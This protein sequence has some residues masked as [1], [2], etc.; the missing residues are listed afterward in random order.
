MFYHCITYLESWWPMKIISSNTTH[1]VSPRVFQHRNSDE[2]GQRPCDVY[3]NFWTQQEHSYWWLVFESTTSTVDDGSLIKTGWY[4]LLNVKWINHNYKWWWYHD[5]RRLPLSRHVLQ[6][7]QTWAIFNLVIWSKLLQLTQG[8][9][10]VPWLALQYLHN[11]AVL[12]KAVAGS[13]PMPF[14]ESVWKEDKIKLNLSVPF[15]LIANKETKSV[16]M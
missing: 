12:R 9:R 11:T 16:A 8:R 3:R 7:I 1:A 2:G 6:A 10:F 14:K 13:I 15:V 4:Y 5:R